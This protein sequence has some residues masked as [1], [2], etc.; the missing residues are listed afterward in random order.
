MA[1]AKFTLPLPP[2]EPVRSYA[3]GSPEKIQLKA[4]LKE[5]RERQ[6]E[7]PLII[8]GKEMRTGKRGKCVLPHHH[9]LVV[10]E[11]HQ[12][13]EK[14]VNH[15]IQ[16]AIAAQE[17]WAAMQWYDRVAIFMK[18]AELLAGPWR[19]TLNAA[20]MLGQSKN[21]FQAEIDAAAE[22]TDFFRFKLAIMPCK[23]LSSEP[24]Y[25][26]LGLGSP[27]IPARWKVI[28]LLLPPSILLPLP[29]ICPLRRPSWAT[30][31][32][33]NR[34]PA[35]FTPLTFSCGSFKKPGFRME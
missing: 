29:A 22:L 19:D 34:P 14:E 24:P 31:F 12:A 25:S 3:P 28:F 35:P 30:L 4:K 8:G 16:A 21:V 33:G 7:I 15:A 6:I 18:A 11:Y 2:N 32:Y 1:N 17:K 10:A 9:Q 27:G 20:T 23:F 26:P 5:M 13:S